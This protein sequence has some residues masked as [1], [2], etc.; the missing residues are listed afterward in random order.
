M[1]HYIARRNRA[2]TITSFIHNWAP[3]LRDQLS[4]IDLESLPSMKRARPGI[5]IF[6]DF[7]RMRL[8]DR[9]MTVRL[10][11]RIIHRPGFVIHNDPAHA[12]AR[13]DLLRTLHDRGLNP[14]NAYRW[15]CGPL[16]DCRYP[17]FIRRAHGHSGARS[18]LLH[19]P[20]ELRMAL[21]KA[22]LRY[23]NIL[24]VEFADVDRPDGVYRKYGAV[25][26]GQHIYPRHIL[27][28]NHWMIK[29][30]DLLSP[31]RFVEERHFIEHG[32]HLAQLKT[33]FD[34]AGL[35]YGRIDYG[36]V[37]GK[38]V[39]WEINSNPMLLGRAKNTEGIRKP[40][41]AR[42]AD[43]FA[44]RLRDDLAAWR[45]EPGETLELSHT[46][47]ALLNLTLNVSNHLHRTPAPAPA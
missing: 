17:V 3:D 9:R 34:T 29:D 21:C 11:D 12:M 13:F 20:A 18:D 16:P 14:F 2:N 26:L 8:G 43:R 7:E 41:N 25:R 47:D 24:I 35:T 28:S 5:Y 39:T 15:T 10:R 1:I 30:P 37:N 33:V 36:F 38:I 32:D 27:F 42:F 46:R 4:V 23:K 45:R 6:T 19:T 22:R 44:N 31:E 40:I